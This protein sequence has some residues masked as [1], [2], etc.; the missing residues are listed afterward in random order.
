M[1]RLEIKPIRNM[2][3]VWYKISPDDLKVGTYLQTTNNHGRLVLKI[4]EVDLIITSK[5]T[6][7]SIPKYGCSVIEGKLNHPEFEKIFKE[8]NQFS[9][10]QEALLTMEIATD[11]TREEKLKNLGL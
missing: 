5:I 8:N 9:F 1:E 11:Y 7:K 10:G 4:T 2:I 6:N 3:K